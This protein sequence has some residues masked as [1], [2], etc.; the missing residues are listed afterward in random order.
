MKDT[1]M[2]RDQAVP[3]MDKQR[4]R[5]EP[6][7]GI[8]KGKETRTFLMEIPL[9]AC[10]ASLP[11]HTL[12]FCFLRFISVLRWQPLPGPEPEN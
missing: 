10:E 6:L 2:S 9:P 12:V 11:P 4:V 1:Q 5:S 7:H 3:I 8:T